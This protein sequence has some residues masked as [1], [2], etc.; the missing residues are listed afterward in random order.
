M[1]ELAAEAH[2]SKG[3]I[4]SSSFRRSRTTS[5]PGQFGKS[6]VDAI[7]AN[8][9]S[10]ATSQVCICFDTPYILSISTLLDFTF[11]SAF[12]GIS[13]MVS[14]VLGTWE[15]FIQLDKVIAGLETA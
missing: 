13:F 3:A 10:L 9:N 7:L 15:M 11:L 8:S 6:S 14:G 2:K 4:H 1:C 5:D 12:T